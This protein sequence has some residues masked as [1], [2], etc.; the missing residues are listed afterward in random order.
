MKIN[1]NEKYNT[2]ATYS[3][4]VISAIIIFYLSI[5][6]LGVL[7]DKISD[8][9]IILQPFII[10]FSIA[11]I[12]NFILRFYEEKLNMFKRFSSKTKRGIGILITYITGFLLLY[13]FI[14]FVLPQL[15][16]SIVGLIND[17]PIYINNSTKFINKLLLDLNISQEYLSLINDNFN[18]FINYTIKVATNLLPVLG[19]VVTAVAS[20]IW[21]IV[22]GTIISIYLLI[23]KE[24]FCGLSKKITY[25]VFPKNAAEKVIEI[26]HRSNDTFGKFLIGKIVDSSIIGVLTFIVLTI[27]NM[28]YTILI[29]VIVGITN[30]IPFFGPF[31][32][33]VPSVIII[34]F[35]SP[36]KALW[37]LIII[38][39]IQQ[40]DG[41]IIG[42]KILG[43]SIGISAFWILFS[44][45]VAGKFLGLIGMIIGVPLFAVIYSII[46]E[47]V[48][49]KLKKKGLKIKTID[50]M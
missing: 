23:D 41:N 43:D 16:D 17:V 22:L 7:L 37:L 25:A 44:I 8:T 33:A 6:Q 5:S 29:S 28:P 46:K 1:W 36:I 2:I 45:L 3:F 13:L 11:Y 32:G 48:E 35:V 34:L 4:I 31:I 26:T 18:D 40:I 12:L 15:V 30:I 39:I 24:K 10:G 21:N 47:V 20:S 42:P 14:Q 50:Y 38:L 19:S 9:V 49:A 27:V